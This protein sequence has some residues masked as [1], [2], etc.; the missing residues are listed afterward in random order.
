MDPS[1]NVPPPSSVGSTPSPNDIP[2]S[3]L[4][5]ST[6]SM[7]KTSI[8]LEEAKWQENASDRL[9]FKNIL[10]KAIAKLFQNAA[11]YNANDTKL[12]LKVKLSGEVELAFDDGYYDEKY[13]S[14]LED[15]IFQGQCMGI[16]IL[17]LYAIWLEH[18][19]IATQEKTSKENRDDWTWL[20]G[21]FQKIANRGLID[22]E[23]EAEVIAEKEDIE[24]FVSLL[25]FY[26]DVSKLLPIS[27]YEF[28][29]YL[30]QANSTAKQAVLL[31]TKNRSLN[32]EYTLAIVTTKNDLQK[33]SNDSSQES[34]EK[35]PQTTNRFLDDLVKENKLVLLMNKDHVMGLLK[36]ND[37]I[38]IV[39]PNKLGFLAIRK[40]SGH[41]KIIDM[42]FEELFADKTEQEPVILHCNE[43]GFNG[44][45]PA[46]YPSQH[47]LLTKFGVKNQ[48]DMDTRDDDGYSVLDY[49]AEI[50][51]TAS[52]HFYLENL[53]EQTNDH[54]QTPLH[55]AGNPAVI[56][57]LITKGFDVST[58]DTDGQTPLHTASN[59]LVAEALIERGA[60]VDAKEKYGQ[61][62]LH[63]A[64]NPAVAEALIK[65]GAKVDAREKYGQTP[66]HTAI[67]SAVAEKLIEHK[68]DVN[69]RGLFKQTPL[70]TAKNPDV[71]ETLIEHKA[72]VN[73]QDKYGQTPLHL[74]AKNNNFS[75]VRILLDHGANPNIPTQNGETPLQLAAK[76][77]HTTPVRLLCSHHAK[78]DLSDEKN[79][80]DAAPD[81]DMILAYL[82]QN[83]VE[84]DPQKEILCAFKKNV[85]T[86]YDEM[87]KFSHECACVYLKNQHQNLKQLEQHLRTINSMASGIGG[88][89]KDNINEKT[90]DLL[91]N[92]E[93]SIYD[94]TDL[95]DSLVE[96]IRGINNKPVQIADV[97]PSADTDNEVE[98]TE[99]ET[100]Q[101]ETEEEVESTTTP[102]TASPFTLKK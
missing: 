88:E 33:K 62:P 6:T 90:D 25:V 70:H 94:F 65:H 46:N 48:V 95:N 37:N 75:V 53:V 41:D 7:P 101:E 13:I 67:N 3:P 54:G 71:A 83:N 76:N 77:G 51:C 98:L 43:F 31:D 96:V 99:Q 84:Q 42:I 44:Q 23:D 100:E 78:L 68:A 79:A 8:N 32:K 18:Q 87:K 49:A 63:T 40:T 14:K 69:A 58:Q 60:K 12:M 26:Q 61:T 10:N 52:L 29:T 91:Q 81:V 20:Y 64:K 72:D 36:I 57:A 24:R 5:A 19:P 16:T 102:N 11:A 55:I 30:D 85:I 15:E 35:D 45:K 47:S 21:L 97:E 73:A 17:S 59:R 86:K 28:Q 50:G 2:T 38:F 93:K 22:S 1:N 56:D 89:K 82:K 74:T 92:A 34:K 9:K 80:I 39:R 4:T 27:Q 66:L